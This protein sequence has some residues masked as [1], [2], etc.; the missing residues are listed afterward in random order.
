MLTLRQIAAFRAVMI[1]G[2]MVRAAD[3][4]CVTQPAISRLIRNLEDELDFALFKRGKGGL[5]PTNEA[6]ALHVEVEQSYIGLDK[7]ARTARQ[8]R[9]KP[10]GQLRIAAT[11]AMS[12][13]FLPGVVNEFARS[14]PDTSVTLHSYTSPTT[15]ENVCNRHYDLGLSMLPINN[16]GVETGPVRH[17]RCVCILPPGDPLAAREVVRVEDFRDRPFISLANTSSTRHKIDAIFEAANVPRKIVIESSSSVSVCSFVELGM[18]VSIIEPFTAQ[19]FSAH[20]GIAR[21]FEPEINFSFATVQPAGI[22]KSPLLSEFMETLDAAI[23]P[24]LIAQ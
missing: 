6:L 12:L 14:H 18:G 20:G 1:S 2:S 17:V 5:Q 23:A 19:Q 9:L 15:V 24:H 10:S 3:M 21:A 13:G 4:M 11:T 8:I 16:E 7:I 22:E